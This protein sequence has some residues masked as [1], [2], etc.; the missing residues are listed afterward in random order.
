[1]GL[2]AGI[3]AVG[4]GLGLWQGHEQKKQLDEA[5]RQQE[6]AVRAQEESLKRKGPDA[7]SMSDNSQTQEINRLN[8]LRAG[9]LGNIKTGSTG[10]LTRAN[11][12]ST[13]LGGAGNKTTLG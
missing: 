4:L 6:A 10:L 9:M 5:Q 1:M 7:I 3:A 11:T 8:R 12:A 2:A 13:A